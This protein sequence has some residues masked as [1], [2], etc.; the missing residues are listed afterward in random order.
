VAV[1]GDPSGRPVRA[2]SD[3]TGGSTGPV[4]ARGRG[5]AAVLG[6]LA[7]LA[8]GNVASFP[9]VEGGLN[10]QYRALDPHWTNDILEVH[11]QRTDQSGDMFALP[12]TLAEVAPDAVLIVP[13]NVMRPD[14]TFTARLDAFAQ[15]SELRSV[16]VGQEWRDWVDRDAIMA[17]VV[18][19]GP[20]FRRPWLISLDPA[21]DHD[22]LVFVRLEE[23]DG[24]QVDVIVESSLLVGGPT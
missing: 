11:A 6:T 13:R 9:A 15:V 19:R 7:V 17:N 21:G 2:A 14:L 20:D 5:V 22:E 1:Q 12:W 4:L 8:V 24:S 3:P 23:D 18:A 10:E 16:D